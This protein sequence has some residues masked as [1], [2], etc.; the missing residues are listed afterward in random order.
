MAKPTSIN[1]SNADTLRV[2]D[3][4]C[5]ARGISRSSAISSLLD[6]TTPILKDITSHY[7][8]ADELNKRLL[9]GVYKRGVAPRQNTDAAEKYC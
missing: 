5:K 6:A 4:Y 7:Q 1:I 9:S 2:L 3:G 8:L